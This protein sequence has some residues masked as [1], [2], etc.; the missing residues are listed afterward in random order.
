MKIFVDNLTIS[1]VE[2]DVRK[3]FAAFG[4]VDRVNIARNSSDG[5]SRGFGFVDVALEADGRA[6]ITGLNG[7]DLLGHTLKVNQARKR[8]SK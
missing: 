7:S 3:A 6:M 8:A 1:T 5:S 4:E 2:D